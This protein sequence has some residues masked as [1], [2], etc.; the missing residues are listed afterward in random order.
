MANLAT[1]K[2]RTLFSG[3]VIGKDINTKY[4]GIPDIYKTKQIRVEYKDQ[5]MTIRD[6]E[7]AE[8]FRVFEDKFG[9]DKNYTLGYFKF[10]PDRSETWQEQLKVENEQQKLI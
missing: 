10:V 5:V 9:R 1:Y 8:A 4:V 7:K 6:W 3:A 2:P